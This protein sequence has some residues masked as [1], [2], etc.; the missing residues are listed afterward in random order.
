MWMMTPRGFYSAVQKSADKDTPFLTVRA[1]SKQDLE[2]LADLLPEDVEPY[3]EERWT[4]YPWRIRIDVADWTKICATLAL[5]IDYSNFKD[6]VKDRQ[7]AARAK[8]YSRVW[9]A[10]RDIERERSAKVPKQ[11]PMAFDWP[12]EED[13]MALSGHR[14]AGEPTTPRKRSRRRAKS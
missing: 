10:L 5:E 8:V 2:N 1:R 3:R 13:A 14:L 11:E 6:A 4:D 9:G 7:G 12:E